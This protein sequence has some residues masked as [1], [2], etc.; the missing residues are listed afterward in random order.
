MAIGG[1]NENVRILTEILL[2]MKVLICFQMEMWTLLE[3]ELE[4]KRYCLTKIYI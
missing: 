3:N 2:V 4:A 1:G